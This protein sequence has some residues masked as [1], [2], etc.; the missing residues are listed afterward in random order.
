MELHSIPSS[1]SQ[2][3]SSKAF[4]GS[5]VKNLPAETGDT[6]SI[7]GSG[8]SLG[9]GH[10]NP[11]QYSCLGKSHG[12]RSLEGYNLWGCN[13]VRHDLVTKQQN[14][15][16][17]HVSRG[18]IATK[19]LER[20]ILLLATFTSYPHSVL[21]YFS[22]V[23]WMFSSCHTHHHTY[24]YCSSAALRKHTL[25]LMLHHLIITCLSSLEIYKDAPS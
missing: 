14:V 8:R 2:V 11:L 6:G 17:I 25:F 22:A 7:P 9:K 18:F 5:V 20:Y 15:F 10:G 23:L 19:C 4:L 3:T 12:Q 16:K 21:L 1:P 13:R 24:Q